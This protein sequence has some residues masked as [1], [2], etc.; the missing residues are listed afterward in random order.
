MQRTI[1]K[2]ASHTRKLKTH[3]IIQLDCHIGAAA[4]GGKP[5]S[6]RT[7]DVMLMLIAENILL[8]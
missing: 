1:H 8:L 7:T 5:P 4:G 2:S 6:E 3:V